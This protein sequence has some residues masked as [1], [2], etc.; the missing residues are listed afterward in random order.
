MRFW[1][2]FA[3]LFL[4]VPVFAHSYRL[5]LDPPAGGTLIKGYGGLQAADQRTAKALVRVITPGNDVD[6]R[7]TVRVLVMN[8]GASPFAFGP[9][10]VTLRLGDGTI[11]APTPVREFA[12]GAML[13]ERESGRAAITDRAN[14]NSFSDL[15][16]AANSGMTAPTPGVSTP[17]GT[18]P[19]QV[20]GQDHRADWL[21]LPGG[22]TLDAIYQ[23]LT[24][25]TIEPQQA[26]GGYYVFDV[27][28]PVQSRRV[29]QP[30]SIIVRTGREE[31]RFPAMLHWK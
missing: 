17:G 18:V 3:A 13:I 5:V 27:P 26:W 1:I 8:L 2:G 7:G 28:K 10:H 30:L 23:L 14:R 29:D 16:R 4:A 12:R 31:H 25:Q 24:L 9:Q 15:A 11:L 6:R 20:Q 21:T 22:Q 19:T